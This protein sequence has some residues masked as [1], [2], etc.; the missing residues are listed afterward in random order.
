MR[1]SILFMALG[2]T[3]LTSAAL[4]VPPAPGAK[5][6]AAP[7][8]SVPKPL[9]PLPSASAGKPAA[10]PPKPV[11]VAK[12][13]PPKGPPKKVGAITSYQPPGY[14]SMVKAWHLATAAKAPSDAAGNA[15]LVLSAINRPE[16]VELVGKSDAGGFAPTEVD[17]ASFIMRSADGHQ[18]PIDPRLLDLVYQLQQH[19]GAGEIRFLSGYRTPKKPGSNHGYGRAMDLVVPGATDEE[20]VTYARTLGFLGVGIYPTSGFV[21]VDVR[22]RSFFWVDKS[23]PGAPNKTVGILGGDAAAS[24]AKARKEGRVGSPPAAIGRDVAAA[25]SARAK[26]VSSSPPATPEPTGVDE[27]DD[28]H[29]E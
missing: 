22:D 16:R 20:V 11:M 26:A 14:L 27:Y 28:E 12:V 4:A 24:D 19:F 9:P 8:A 7:S 10:S 23:G 1:P 18:H 5:G 6:S 15:K 17:K 25:L 21:H 2:T 13:S 29:D 3:V